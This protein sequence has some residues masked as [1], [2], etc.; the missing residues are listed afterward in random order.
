MYIFPD[1][2]HVTPCPESVPAESTIL[3]YWYVP[4]ESNLHTNTA[5]P[6]LDG[7]IS[8]VPPICVLTTGVP[9]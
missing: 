7:R 4:V 8:K 3:E 5:T 9:V 1:E 2:S 6:E